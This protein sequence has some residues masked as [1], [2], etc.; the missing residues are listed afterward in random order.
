MALFPCSANATHPDDYQNFVLRHYR[1]IQMT[2]WFSCWDT[3]G[4]D[5]FC[6]G[7]SNTQ[8]NQYFRYDL[9]SKQIAHG[10]VSLGDCIDCDL[11]KRRVVVVPCNASSPTQKW[12][13]GWI[14]EEK[15]RHW[16]KNGAPLA[17]K[18]EIKDLEA[19][20]TNDI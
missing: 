16:T 18:Q 9:K 10:P 7:C 15:V 20:E 19:L 1:D 4:L 17:N 5:V 11:E 2:K 14:F 3:H 8:E 6:T 12:E 13:W